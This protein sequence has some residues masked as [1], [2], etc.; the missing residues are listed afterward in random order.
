[1]TSRTAEPTSNLD[2]ISR[3]VQHRTTPRHTCN[4]TV[5]TAVLR[6]AQKQATYVCEPHHPVPRFQGYV[7]LL[8]GFTEDYLVVLKQ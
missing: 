3:F 8:D 1:M 4:L 5:H 6:Q 2:L 7:Y